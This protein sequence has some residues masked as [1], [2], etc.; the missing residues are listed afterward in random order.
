MSSRYGFFREIIFTARNSSYGKVMFSQAC[1]NNSVHG[2]GVRGIHRSPGTHA[3]PGMPPSWTCMSQGTHAP[4]AFMPPPPPPTEML[5]MSGRYASYWNAFL[6]D[7]KF[8]KIIC[9]Q[10][11]MNGCGNEDTLYPSFC[12]ISL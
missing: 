8:V 4:W 12:S 6:F 10:I 7:D 2:G 3:P 9:V 5:S 11:V 1:V